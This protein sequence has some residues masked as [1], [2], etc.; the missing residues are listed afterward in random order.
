[1]KELEELRA[2]MAEKDSLLELKQ[3]ELGAKDDEIAG[4][5]KELTFH[6]EEL[7]AARNALETK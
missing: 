1:M 2:Q 6:A 5:H 3:R 4:K 7:V